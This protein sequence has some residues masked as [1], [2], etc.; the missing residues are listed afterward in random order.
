MVSRL[1][2]S[3]A[4][5]RRIA[6][7]W[8]VDRAK[9]PGPLLK[10][11][12]RAPVRL[13]DLNAGWLLGHRFLLLTHRGRRTGRRYRCPL[14]VLVWR[15]DVREAIVMAGFGPKSQWY[16]NVLAGGATEVQ[17]ARQRFAPVARQ[18]EAEEATTVIAAY[19]QR[20][21]LVRPIVRAVLS[22]QAGFPYDGSDAARRRLVEALPLVGLGARG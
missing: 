4:R 20:N 5:T 22:R 16:R 17:I 12:L 13:Y 6:H 18:L 1:T 10:R 9:P 15:P 7:S 19:E 2:A 3:S 21:R 8:R 11:V 14:E